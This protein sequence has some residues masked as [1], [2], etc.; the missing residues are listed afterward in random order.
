M[1][2]QRPHTLLE[3]LS[4]CAEADGGILGEQRE[5]LALLYRTRTSLYNQP[6]AL[7]LDYARPGEVMP[8][9]EPTDDDQRTR[10]D[11]TVTREGGSSARAVREDGPLSIQPL[12]A[13]VGLYD[14]TI[15][16]N[17]A[18]DEQAEPL[19]AWRLHLG[20]TDELRYPTVTLN[21]V[22]APHLIPAV[23]GLEAGDKLVIRNLPDWLPPGDAELLVEGWREQLRPYGWTITLTCSPARPWTVGVTDDPSLGRADTDGTELDDDAG[24]A[25]TELVVRT[26]AGP[27]WVTD[28]P[29][30]PFDVRVGGEVVT[31]LGIT[32]SRPQTM[33]VRRATDGTSTPHP[34]GTDVRL[35]QPTVV[36][37]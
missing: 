17:L 25:D 11:V 3:L 35:A 29:E 30:F 37:L 10:N 21:L 14:E 22:R 27:P 7:V 4:E 28:A 32:G 15:T 12:P 8:T 5:G 13:G 34:A 20:T 1:G 33:T 9:L 24:A 18:R 19:A 2:P 16:L 6:P 23:L 31:V 36:A 26:T